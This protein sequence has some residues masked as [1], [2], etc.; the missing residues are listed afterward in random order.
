MI[1]KDT[2]LAI[3]HKAV[4]ATEEDRVEAFQFINDGGY[5]EELT[6]LELLEL[7][8]LVES[9]KVYSPILYVN[10]NEHILS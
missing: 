10:L 9:A 4:H 5:I 6:P 1:L 8:S 3:I 7:R 2:A